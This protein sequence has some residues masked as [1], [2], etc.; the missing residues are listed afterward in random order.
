[1]TRQ[2]LKHLRRAAAVTEDDALL[3]IGS[4]SILGAYPAV[5]GPA[6]RGATGWALAPHDLAASMYAAGRP[7]DRDFLRS[8]IRHRLLDRATT[9]ERIDGL[10]AL[11]AERRASL[12]TLAG[13][14]FDS[15]GG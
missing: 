14:D 15:A 4:Q 5:N 3:V 2:Q 7:K 1:M 8:A 9:L 12:R 11:P 6:T 10:A 13:A